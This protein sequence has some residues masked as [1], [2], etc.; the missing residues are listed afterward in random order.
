MSILSVCLSGRVRT[1]HRVKGPGVRNNKVE[2]V[3]Y[4][5]IE[6]IKYKSTVGHAGI[7][8]SLEAIHFLPLRYGEKIISWY[9]FIFRCAR[10]GLPPS[11]RNLSSPFFFCLVFFLML[12]VFFR[13]LFT[14]QNFFFPMAATV[15][16]P[17]LIEIVWCGRSQEKVRLWCGVLGGL[18]A[19]GGVAAGLWS[20]AYVRLCVCHQMSTDEWLVR[21]KSE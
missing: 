4:I 14:R 13:L 18:G 10:P 7:C 20:V 19:T 1:K 9:L 2:L 6:H 16:M 15:C 12:V 21:M 17:G 8:F 11:R 5:Y 3:L